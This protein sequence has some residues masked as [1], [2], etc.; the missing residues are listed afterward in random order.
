MRIHLSLGQNASS[1]TDVD[2]DVSLDNLSSTDLGQTQDELNRKLKQA[3][4]DTQ[5]VQKVTR[6][7]TRR[8]SEYKNCV[9]EL[10]QQ[11]RPIGQQLIQEL[12]TVDKAEHETLGNPQ[13]MDIIPEHSYEDEPCSGDPIPYRDA[14]G[15]EEVEFQSSHASLLSAGSESDR[16]SQIPVS[17]AQTSTVG[18]NKSR[19]RQNSSNSLKWHRRV[20]VARFDNRNAPIALGQAL[21]ELAS[22]QYRSLPRR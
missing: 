10:S 16:N 15:F 22:K 13:M 7:N 12:T 3:S 4:C 20:S 19:Q 1:D 5:F 21:Q 14:D 6:L 18:P 17:E 2:I 8:N 9:I 11:P